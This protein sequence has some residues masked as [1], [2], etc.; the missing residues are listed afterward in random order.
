M[1]AQSILENGEVYVMETVY[2]LL[3]LITVSVHGRR[4]EKLLLKEQLVKMHGTA[5]VTETV[6]LLL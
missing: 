3:F 1:K 5:F 4:M 2:L 6:C